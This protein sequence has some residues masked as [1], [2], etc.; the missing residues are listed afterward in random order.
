MENNKKGEKIMNFEQVVAV[1]KDKTIY[2]DGNKLIKLF[3]ES[4]SVANVLN[5]A[6]NQAR[7]EET[8]LNIPKLQEVTTIDGK[9]VISM[10]FIEG[11][12][13]EQLLTE[14]PQ[15]EDKYLKLF[16]DTQID[17]HSKRSTLLR[18]LHDKMADKIDETDLDNTIKFDLKSKLAG[19]EKHNK[20]LHGDYQLS[21]VMV[22]NDGKIYI[23]DWS[24]AT[25]GNA[26]ADVAM[27][28]L[29]MKMNGK[30][31]LAEKYLD[32]FCKSTNTEKTYVQRWV[33]IV[34]GAHLKKCKPENKEMLLSYIDVV[35]Y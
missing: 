16:V 8:E 13:L 22:S 21:N 20:V 2:R 31:D 7:I 1:R 23:V 35:E 29:L 26:S 17:M 4:Y 15:K 12:T 18:K 25:Q 10:D 19:F 34:A 24:H 9:W 30:T 6:L 33:P 28:Y 27:S 11:K 3:D 5:E 14:N 32:L